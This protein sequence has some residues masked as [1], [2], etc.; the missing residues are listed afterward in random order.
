MFCWTLTLSVKTPKFHRI[1]PSSNVSVN[2]GFAGFALCSV[3]CLPSDSRCQ[4]IILIVLAQLSTELCMGEPCSGLHFSLNSCHLTLGP[5]YQTLSSTLHRCHVTCLSLIL[6][7]S[8]S[9]TDRDSGCALFSVQY[10]ILQTKPY[11][12]P[13]CNL[14]SKC[15]K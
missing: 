12:L 6:G 11:S 7:S 5:L 8:P 2:P 3:M 15:N 9:K 1:V 13:L 10:T 14:T 4:C